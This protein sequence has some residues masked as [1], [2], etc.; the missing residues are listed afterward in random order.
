VVKV[1]DPMKTCRSA[2]KAGSGAFSSVR[3]NPPTGGVV[4]SPEVEIVIDDPSQL[5]IVN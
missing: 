4:T 5:E 1:H 2:R 3:I